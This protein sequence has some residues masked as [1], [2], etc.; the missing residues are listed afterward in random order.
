MRVEGGEGGASAAPLP[1]LARDPEP[2]IAFATQPVPAIRRAPRRAAVANGFASRPWFRATPP[3][4][5]GT[6]I[7]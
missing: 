2:L 6:E 3:H 1:T 5:R 7:S 4:G